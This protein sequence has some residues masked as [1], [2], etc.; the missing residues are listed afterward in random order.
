[1]VPRSWTNNP[2]PTRA[3]PCFFSFYVYDILGGTG[4]PLRKGCIISHHHVRPSSCPA[5]HASHT[6]LPLPIA[7]GLDPRW[8]VRAFPPV[9]RLFLPS[10]LPRSHCS[11]RADVTSPIHHISSHPIPHARV[12]SAAGRSYPLLPPLLPPASRTL[13]PG[14][15]ISPGVRL[16]WCT[17]SGSH[18]AVR[19]CGRTQYRLTW[20]VTV[21]MTD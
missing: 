4:K 2:T 20:T 19:A 16:D 7:R 18:L 5:P 21:T 8:M 10:R 13:A 1:M 6:Y 14:S 15:W 12:G 17:G 9:L 11:A 3:V